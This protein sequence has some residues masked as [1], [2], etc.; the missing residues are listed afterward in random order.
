M[1]TYDAR[2]GEDFRISAPDGVF[3]SLE[4][5]LYVIDN[6]Y[7]LNWDRKTDLLKKCVLKTSRLGFFTV[8]PWKPGARKLILRLKQ[9]F[10]IVSEY[11]GTLCGYFY[12]TSDAVQKLFIIRKT[13]GEKNSGEWGIG[14]C[15]EEFDP[16]TRR[17]FIEKRT[18]GLFHVSGQPRNIGCYLSLGEMRQITFMTKIFDDLDSILTQLFASSSPND[19]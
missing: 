15:I 8:E 2:K 1:Q 11:E 14:G 6:A 3:S 5:Q 10:R 13:S 19:I 12:I 4:H 16:P 18:W 9:E 17:S 7:N